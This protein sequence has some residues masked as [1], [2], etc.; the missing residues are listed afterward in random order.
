[1]TN[2]NCVAI[3]GSRKPEELSVRLAKK[4][5]E[6]LV[7]HNFTVVSG[8]AEGIDAAAH[9]TTL[10]LGGTTI[11]VLGHGVSQTFPKSTARLRDRISQRNGS[12]ISE[13]FPNE[14]Y[15]RDHF[16]WRN[17]IQSGLSIAVVPI[18][19]GT[20]GGTARTVR[21]AIEQHKDVFGV[22]FSHASPTSNQ[23]YE[24]LNKLG[25]P[26]FQIPDETNSIIRFLR[27][28]HPT[29]NS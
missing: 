27:S 22:M 2:N 1:M 16:L 19:S 21:F 18:E 7:S 9:E 10:A 20:S 15:S 29:D 11:A 28:T 8:L 13:Y 12:V 25:K 23:V 14:T 24:L 3:V 5:T 6:L 4:L 17:R 26:I